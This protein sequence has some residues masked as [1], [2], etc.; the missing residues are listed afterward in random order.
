[1][2]I[3]D[4]EEIKKKDSF[5]SAKKIVQITPT[6]C[7]ISSLNEKLPLYAVIIDFKNPNLNKQESKY[8]G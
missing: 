3:I 6:H 2:I 7:K 5:V 4:G 1:M 8:L